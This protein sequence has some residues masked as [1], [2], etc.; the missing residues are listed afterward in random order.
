[1]ARF[2]LPF[3]KGWKRV[4]A[5]LTS[6]EVESLGYRYRYPLRWVVI[7]APG[8]PEPKAGEVWE[9]EPAK[10]VR[11]GVVLGRLVRCVES[12]DKKERLDIGE[13]FW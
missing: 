7:P 9:V 4:V 10:V 5:F 12:V 8:S 2:V 3:E 6:D 11:E 1:M 13:K